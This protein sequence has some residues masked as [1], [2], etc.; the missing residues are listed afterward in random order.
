MKT[1][2]RNAVIVTVVLFVCV[3]AYLNWSYGKSDGA[4]PSDVFGDELSGSIDAADS[5][6]ETGGSGSGL[7]FSGDS[8]SSVSG[9]FSE[10]RLSRKQARDAAVETLSTLQDSSTASQAVIDSAL[11]KLADIAAFSQKES[12]IEAL[13]RAKGFRDCVVFISDGSVKITVPAPAAGLTTADVAKITEIVTTETK[14][15]AAALNII[16]IK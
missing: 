13:I 3:A 15:P 6:S 10:V 8:A 2:K 16:E 11:G 1:F 14:L 4:T 7:Y 12:E 5:P 9:Y